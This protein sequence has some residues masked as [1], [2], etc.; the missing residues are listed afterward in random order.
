MYKNVVDTTGQR[1]R[2][3]PNK[4]VLALVTP[5]PKNYISCMYRY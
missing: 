1:A 5:Y 4:R 2:L 3:Y